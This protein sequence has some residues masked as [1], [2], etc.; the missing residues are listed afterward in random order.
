MRYIKPTWEVEGLFDLS[1]SDNHAGSLYTV[2]DMMKIL[3][4]PNERKSF[5]VEMINTGGYFG[6][7]G[8]IKE[9]DIQRDGKWKCLMNH[10]SLEKPKRYQSLSELELVEIINSTIGK[11]NDLSIDTQ[12]RVGRYCVDIKVNLKNK[13]YYIEFLGPQHF[14]SDDKVERDRARRNYLENILGTQIVEWPYWIQLCEQN[15]RI[16]FGENLKGR[17]A[18]WGSEVFF[19]DSSNAVKQRIISL[20]KSFRAIRED[21]IGYFYE[22]WKDKDGNSIK[23]SHPIVEKI[24]NGEESIEILLPANVESE[25][26]MFWLPKELWDLHHVNG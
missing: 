5:F 4:I 26:K 1:D 15:V 13:D 7:D 18:I 9:P 20:S 23:P 6:R 11:D 8:R 14:N 25:G 3:S 21:G 16:A 19:G 24:K 2:E 22:E 12:F 10:C 17:G